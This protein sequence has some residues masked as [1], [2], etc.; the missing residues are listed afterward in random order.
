LNGPYGKEGEFQF[1]ALSAE[2][3]HNPVMVL[4]LVAVDD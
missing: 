3:H 2:V 4:Q 1:G